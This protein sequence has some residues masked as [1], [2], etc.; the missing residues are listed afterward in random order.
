[1]IS[2]ERRALPREVGSV[3]AEPRQ[4]GG[5]RF[6]RMLQRTHMKR[7]QQIRKQDRSRTPKKKL[8]AKVE[9]PRQQFYPHPL[10]GPI[11][12]LPVE[13]VLA[14]GAIH[15]GLD[16]DPD[17][18]PTMPKGA[19][20]GDVRAQEFCRQCHV[21]RYFY[22]DVDR[23]CVQCGEEF[24]FSAREQ[25]YWFEGLKFHFDSRAIR[26]RA[27]RRSR[28]S[29]K[30]LNAQL[31]ALATDLRAR[32]KDAALWVA[33]AEA[34]LRLREKT[35][36]GDLDKALAS[37]RKAEKIWPEHAPAIYWQARAQDL[38]GREVAA[39][40]TYARFLDHPSVRRHRAL[41]RQ[42]R[43]RLGLL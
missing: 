40:A 6:G 10:Y 21:P 41:W 8:P 36:H 3:E 14:S 42:A 4:E 32:P 22:V 11:P 17:Y 25:K 34:L 2:D 18:Q 30:A 1:M 5:E 12:M 23:R 26:C 15:H 16:Y 39:L 24:T 28:R 7:R 27:C 20:R 9:R 38:L 13:V 43:V 37:A 35:G 19:V 33:Q 31:S 29:D